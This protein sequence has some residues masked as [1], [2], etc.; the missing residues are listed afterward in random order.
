MEFLEA[1]TPQEIKKFIDSH[2]G[3]IEVVAMY[4][5]NARHYVW[6]KVQTKQ[7]NRSK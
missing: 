3:E 7:K 1:K 2:D 5:V 4:A 6:Y